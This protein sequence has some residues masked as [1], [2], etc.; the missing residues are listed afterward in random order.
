LV[1]PDLLGRHRLDLED[2]AG[3]ALEREAGDD[4]SR[5]LGVA[6]PVDHSAGRS[7]GLLELLE[8]L[9]QVVGDLPFQG[10]AG[11]AQLLPVTDLADRGGPFPLDGAGGVA[12]VAPQ[13]RVRQVGAGR[14][15]EGAI[16]A[17]L[18]GRRGVL[19]AGGG[20][21]GVDGA[22]EALPRRGSDGTKGSSRVAARIC[23]RWIGCGAAPVRPSL[24]P[25]FI[26][27]EA[28]PATTKSAPLETTLAAL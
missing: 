27:Q 25:M 28:S 19:G 6:G 10:A 20:D 18:R 2:L 14:F 22:H 24:P 15:G 8:H 16:A 13:G 7:D 11:A 23:A 9:R 12:Q 26:R 1:Q 17:Q 4:V 3:L 21:A 5:L